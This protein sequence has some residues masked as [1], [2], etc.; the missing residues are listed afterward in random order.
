MTDST[1]PENQA[2]GNEESLD[3]FLGT[4]PEKPWRKW[5]KWGVIG[6]VLFL[7][8]F[9]L[10]RCFS[11]GDQPNYATREARKGDLTVTVSATG[12]LKPINQVDVGSEQSGKITDVYVDVNDRVTKGQKLAEVDTRRLIDSVNQSRAQVSSSQ[13]GVTQ[14]RANLA[15]PRQRSTGRRMSTSFPAAASPPR[16]RWTAPVQPMNR[17]S[18]PSARPRRR[19]KYPTPSFPRPRPTCRSRRSFRR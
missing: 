3:D 14:A 10:S 1:T 19:Y 12:N 2:P 7:L 15:S 16:R 8:V 18:R 5:V 11:S 9:L 13:A 17:L 4:R 6:L